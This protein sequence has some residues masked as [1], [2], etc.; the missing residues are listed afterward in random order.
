[1]IV[2]RNDCKQCHRY[3][4]VNSC[5]LCER[6][7]AKQHWFD[8]ND[9]G[10][11][12]NLPREQALAQLIGKQNEIQLKQLQELKAIAQTLIAKDPAILI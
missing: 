3:G 8:L 6:C 7:G 4:V 10:N 2:V 5:N 12:K 11:L 1:M 9:S